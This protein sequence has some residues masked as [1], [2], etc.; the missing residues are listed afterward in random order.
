[1]KKFPSQEI[2]LNEI[3]QI[4]IEDEQRRKKIDK[5]QQLKQQRQNLLKNLYESF[6]GSN[7]SNSDVSS[8]SSEIRSPQ[9]RDCLVFPANIR[10]DKVTFIDDEN[11]SR[12]FISKKNSHSKLVKKISQLDSQRE[13]NF[14]IQ[15]INFSEDYSITNEFQ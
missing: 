10:K 11:E 12:S 7:K 9:Q 2:S 5:L 1:M 6:S 15:P 13:S 14:K 8:Y 4:R 3:K